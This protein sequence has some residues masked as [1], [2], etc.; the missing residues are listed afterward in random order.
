MSKNRNSHWSIRRNEGYI[1]EI[2]VRDASMA[3]NDVFK[4]NTMDKRSMENVLNILNKKYGIKL[5]S[6]RI[7]PKVD[8]DLE[9]LKKG[10]P[11]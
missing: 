7:T 4:F 1:I 9:W 11:F 2:I 10:S 5:V 8:K 3:K 6:E